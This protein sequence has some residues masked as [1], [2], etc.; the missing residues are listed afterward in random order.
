MI[1][2]LA[3]SF[4]VLAGFAGA[5]LLS[6]YLLFLA[7]DINAA[8]AYVAAV[9]VALLGTVA[10]IVFGFLVVGGIGEWW[11]WVKGKR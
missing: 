9:P 7:P 4:G 1:K 11:S 5:Y 6:L 3:L 8:S 10:L 2:R